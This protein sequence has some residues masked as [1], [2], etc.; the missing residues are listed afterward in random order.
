MDLIRPPTDNLYKFLAISGLVLLGLSSLGEIKIG[1][2]LVNVSRQPYVDLL[3]FENELSNFVDDQ[4]YFEDVSEIEG[5]L[6]VRYSAIQAADS[7]LA[8]APGGKLMDKA[9]EQEVFALCDEIDAEL[10]RL[11]VQ[12]CCESIEAYLGLAATKSLWSCGKGLDSDEFTAHVEKLKSDNFKDVIAERKSRGRKLQ[13]DFA[14]VTVNLE[15][16]VEGM[17]VIQEW[18]SYFNWGRTVGIAVSIMGFILW[19]SKVQR[20]QDLLLF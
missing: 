6:S 16:A 11:A 18:K 5:K 19:Y 7:R 8:N 4:K 10:R 13:A 12:P 9:L 2:E 17:Y 15:V 1:V 3:R 20:H 14:E